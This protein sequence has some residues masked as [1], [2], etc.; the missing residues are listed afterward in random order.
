LLVVAHTGREESLRAGIQVCRQLTEA[1]LAPVLAA[2]EHRD[3]LAA[4]P[5]LAH[6]SLLGR[7]V[8]TS[9]LELVIVLGGDGTILRAAE[10]ARE[11]DAPLLGVNLGHVGFLAEAERDDLA[12]AVRRA[13][14]RDYGVEERM[15]LSVRVKVDTEV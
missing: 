15:T 12:E 6:V 7:D 8:S 3:L 1:G 4:A 2:D 10:L 13:L 9:E 11:S 14:A 5:E